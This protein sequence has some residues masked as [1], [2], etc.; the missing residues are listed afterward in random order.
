MKSDGCSV[1]APLDAPTEKSAGS[2]ERSGEFPNGGRNVC[3]LDPDGTDVTVSWN[4]G[5]T[6]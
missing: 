1:G 5:E 2:A 3:G 4:V 6:C